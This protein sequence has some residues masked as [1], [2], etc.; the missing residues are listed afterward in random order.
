MFA[1]ISFEYLKY[2]NQK[3]VTTCIN[4]LNKLFIP[5]EL[6]TSQWLLKELLETH[7]NSLRL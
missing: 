4:K 1:F 7:L 6:Q 2:F 3:S 5:N